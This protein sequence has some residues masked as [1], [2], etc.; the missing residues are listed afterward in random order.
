MSFAKSKKPGVPDGSLEPVQ[1]G[2]L[3]KQPAAG[4][5]V[6]LGSAFFEQRAVSGMKNCTWR[7]L[8]GRRSCGVDA[9]LRRQEC[10][11]ELLV[12]LEPDG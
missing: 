10:C 5:E 1:I 3:E 7:E 6:I 12:F 11:G 4:C 8:V 2:C 9:C